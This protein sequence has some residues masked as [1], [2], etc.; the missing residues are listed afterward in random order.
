MIPSL[1]FSLDEEPLAHKEIERI[2]KRA[3]ADLDKTFL[4]ENLSLSFG[5]TFLM[6]FLFVLLVF[7]DTQLCVELFYSN[8]EFSI[9]KAFFLAIIVSG[10]LFAG[11]KFRSKRER[12]QVYLAKLRPVTDQRRVNLLAKMEDQSQKIKAYCDKVKE[13][14]RGRLV[15]AEWKLASR[16][17]AA[18]YAKKKEEAKE[19]QEAFR[20]RPG[21]F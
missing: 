16:H 3:K 11:F 12:L 13:G 7:G 1:R 19:R 6:F 17:Y 21:F 9:S 15:E 18:N 14:D 5:A 2:R 20:G 8:Y 4:L 10:A